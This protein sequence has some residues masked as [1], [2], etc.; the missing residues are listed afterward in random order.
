[1]YTIS[2]GPQAPENHR[3]GD[4]GGDDNNGHGD[5]GYHGNQTNLYGKKT[6]RQVA[7]EHLL[8]RIVQQCEG[9]LFSFG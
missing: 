8:S 2:S 6:A 9:D 4:Q 7:G 3:H 1:M 5:D